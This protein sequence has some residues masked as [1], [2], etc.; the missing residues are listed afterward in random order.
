MNSGRRA[1]HASSMSCN[2]IVG[3]SWACAWARP[4]STS[5]AVPPVARHAV[6]QNRA[7]AL[8]QQIG[9]GRLAEQVRT[10][11]AA[12]AIGRKQLV[13]WDKAPMRLCV[14]PISIAA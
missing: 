2:T 9:F 10:R 3:H 11:Q 14:S 1:R 8:F 7:I 12:F 4:R 5:L 6:P 13:G